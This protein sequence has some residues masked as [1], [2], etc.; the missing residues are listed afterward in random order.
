MNYR[1][2]EK[3]V[4]RFGTFLLKLSGNASVLEGKFLAYAAEPDD[5]REGTIHLTKRSDQT[6]NMRRV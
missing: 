6:V 2:S 5:L 3:R 1:D 4:M